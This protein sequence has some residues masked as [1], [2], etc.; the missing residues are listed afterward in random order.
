MKRRYQEIVERMKKAGNLKNESAVAR[1]LG[2]TPQALSNYKKRDTMPSGL[3]LKFADMTGV[4]IDW[5][6]YGG[7]D[8]ER[9]DVKR[10]RMPISHKK[11]IGTGGHFPAAI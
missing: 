4:S 6:V 3:I 9:K 5:L 11:N 1:R 2:V 7:D 10:V 8:M